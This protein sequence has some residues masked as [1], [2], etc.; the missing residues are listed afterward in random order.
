M[1]QI[2]SCRFR[3]LTWN[4]LIYIPSNVHRKMQHANRT[5]GFFHV[6]IVYT[7]IKFKQEQ[8]KMHSRPITK[9]RINKIR[10]IMSHTDVLVF[11]IENIAQ[12]YCIYMILLYGDVP[13]IHQA[14]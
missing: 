3:E 8:F 2:S 9:L 13:L 6:A 10:R 7:C 5:H 14:H 11:S 1:I 4:F 12:V